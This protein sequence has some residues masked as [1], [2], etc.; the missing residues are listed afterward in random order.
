M[1]T[2]RPRNPFRG[3]GE[4]PVLSPEGEAE[5]WVRDLEEFV[6]DV[7]ITTTGEADTSPPTSST[8]T[9]R[10]RNNTTS[11]TRHLL[12]F[13]K[14]SYTT[15]LAK[16]KEEKKLLMIVLTCEEHEDDAVFK[17]TVLVDEE[18]LK[19][20]REEN[21]LCWGGDIKSKDG[22]E[23]LPPSLPSPSPTPPPNP[24][25]KPTVSKTLQTFHLPS[26]SFI[27]LLPPSPPTSSPTLS[28]ITRLEGPPALLPSTLLPLLLTTVLPRV[29]PFLSRLKIQHQQLL[30]ERSLRASQDEAFA[31]SSL[32][33]V[34]RVLLKRRELDL[35]KQK[36]KEVEERARELRAVEERKRLLRGWGEWKLAQ[37]ATRGEGNLRIGV[38]LG[39]GRRVVRSF[40]PTDKVADLYSWVEC[41]LISP[42]LS[43]S[44]SPS[45][46]PPPVEF[47]PNFEFTLAQTFPHRPL[48]LVG[49]TLGEAGVGDGDNFVV[50]GLGRRRESLEGG[51]GGEEEEEEE[52][53]E[54]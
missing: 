7:G 37:L 9:L 45:P 28:L 43:T 52:E 42:S 27:S 8:S 16:A 38:R 22:Y 20:V 33:D 6:G 23:G 26:I 17:K 1:P 24:L 29:K 54:E 15:A 3:G 44:L 46:S 19:L 34:E 53:E 4:R 40:F 2:L 10:R 32:K 48:P 50:E 13:L 21:I 12:P 51:R 35:V 49:K 30:L 41:L 39:D 31:Q 47:T 25:H 5:R 36:E 14:T 11:T 18:L